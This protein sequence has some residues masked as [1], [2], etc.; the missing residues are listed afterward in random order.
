M[1]SLFSMKGFDAAFDKAVTIPSARVK[2]TVAKLRRKHPR[3]TPE[4][5]IAMLD[6]K[7]MRLAKTS[8]AGVGVAAA[9]PAVGTA[10]AVGLTGAQMAAFV[11]A[12]A[13]HVMAVAEVY[14]VPTDDIDRRRT[15]LLTALLGEE[16]AN[17]VQASLGLSTVH[18]ARQ[19]LTKMPASTVKSVNA[20]LRKRAA[21]KAAAKGG[22]VM[23]GRLAP[24]GV[25]AA[26]GWVGGKAMGQSV[27]DGIKTAFGPAPLSF[28]IADQNRKQL[29]DSLV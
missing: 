9:V 1:A 4:Q 29:E 6:K 25:G 10:A 11:A 15:L 21:K 13:F 3:A 2:Q 28:E 27:L 5:I 19:A 26:V 17:A 18:W 20:A 16:G 22:T 12:T 7:Y 24:F 14:G 23:L 8:G